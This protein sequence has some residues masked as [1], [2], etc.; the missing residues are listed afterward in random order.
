MAKNSGKSQ[1]PSKEISFTLDRLMATKP[2]SEGLVDALRFLRSK[3]SVVASR[4]FWSLIDRLDRE[5]SEYR[6]LS[7]EM[8]TEKNIRREIH[9]IASSVKIIV[10]PKVFA[11]RLLDGDE[12]FDYVIK[13]LS[14]TALKK[15]KRRAYDLVRDS[16]SKKTI[17]E[18]IKEQRESIE[19]SKKNITHFK[20]ELQKAL[21]N[22]THSRS[23]L[24]YE[25]KQLIELQRRKS[26][27]EKVGEYLSFAEFDPKIMIE[28][29]DSTFGYPSLPKK[30]LLLIAE[31][32][33]RTIGDDTYP[34]PA[35]RSSH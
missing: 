6:G 8:Q 18:S 16:L 32:M 35:R 17:D 25:K 19:E 22:L 4:K 21:T 13:L 5:I 28:F 14:P 1:S 33:A 11:E 30:K 31:E 27:G 9:K 12:F 26:S 24:R 15:Y 29:G 3:R 23:L 20:S 34:R 2:C 7:D 10:K